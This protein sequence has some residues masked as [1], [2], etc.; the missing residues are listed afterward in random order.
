MAQVLHIILIFSSLNILGYQGFHLNN[1]E[2]EPATYNLT[3]KMNGCQNKNVL[4]HFIPT[5]LPFIMDNILCNQPNIYQQCPRT[6]N[7]CSEVELRNNT[8]NDLKPELELS[9]GNNLKYLF[10]FFDSLFNKLIVFM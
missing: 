2:N 3:W 9:T 8:L 6:C 1:T 5:F 4:C 10:L 7:R